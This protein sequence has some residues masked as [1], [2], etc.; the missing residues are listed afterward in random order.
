VTSSKGAH[1]AHQFQTIDASTL[2]KPGQNSCCLSPGAAVR[3]RWLPSSA[4]KFWRVNG[5][6]QSVRANTVV[7]GTPC[8]GLTISPHFLHL[9]GVDIRVSVRCGQGDA[10]MRS[11]KHVCPCSAPLQPL[12]RLPFPATPILV[13]FCAHLTF[14]RLLSCPISHLEPQIS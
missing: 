14:H 8:S 11:F 12:L 9:V 2:L 10:A 6:P 4:Q 5:D 7:A 1:L 3:P 13:I